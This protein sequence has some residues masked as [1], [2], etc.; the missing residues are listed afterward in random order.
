[1]RCLR[2]FVRWARGAFAGLDTGF[3]D[4]N[5]VGAA[6]SVP[7]TNLFSFFLCHEVFL[8]CRFVIHRSV[9]ARAFAC[10]GADSAGDAGGGDQGEGGLPGGAAVFGAE[11]GAGVVGGDDAG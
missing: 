4:G 9:G 1:M 5:G 7:V 6:L 10:A 8:F 11:G 3:A 2:Q